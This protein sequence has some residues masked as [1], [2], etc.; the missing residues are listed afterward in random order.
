VVHLRGGTT[1]LALVQ[2]DLLGGSAVVQHLVAR[3][4]AETTDVPLAGLYI[5]ATHTHAGP[6][7][8]LGT[9]FYNKFA[10]N[11]PGFDPAW[12]QFLVQQIADG[13]QQAVDTRRPAR[14]AVGSTEVWGLTRNRS[15]EPH[16]RNPSV[17]DARLEPQR[18]FVSVNPWL[19]LL[20]V[21]AEASDGGFEPLAASVIFSVHGTGISMKSKEYNADVWAYLCDELSRRIESGT[22]TRAVVGAMEGTHADVAPAI[23]PATA[24]HLE[25]SRIGRGIGA[26]AAALHERLEAELSEQVT[27]GCGT[28]EIDLDVSTEVDGIRLPRRPAVGAALVAGAHENLTPVIH[29]VP[30]FTPGTP[31]RR[32]HPD[33]GGK[34]VL[35]GRLGQPLVLRLKMMPSV[36]P[37]QVLRIGDTAIVGLPFE[38]TVDTGRRIESAVGAAVEGNGIDRVVVSSVANEYTGYVTTPEEYARQHYEG[39]HTL[40][41]PRT[42]PFLTA[43]AARLARAVAHDGFVSEPVPHRHFDLKVRRFLAAPGGP[44]VERRSVGRAVFEDPTPATDGAWEVRWFDVS[45]GDLDWHN[46]FARIE[47]SDGGGP[48]E[49]ATDGLRPVDD[50]GCDLQ[51]SHLGSGEEGHRYGVRWWNP[52]F[53]A[54]RRHRLVLASNGPQPEWASEPFD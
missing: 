13:V 3:A 47:R 51:V 45:P 11:K 4:V 22:G 2:C 26:H 52:S 12:T 32:Q 7:Q 17:T 20:R 24:G 39:G 48:W 53:R 29:R 14:L 6:G 10:S 40:F 28:R 18:K 38:L 25:A 27:L 54:G 46:P 16:T 1:S 19:H 5:G 21:D 36:L 35:G 15:L 30:P 33:Q 41:G 42:Q 50:Q 37:L 49:P 43:H 31:K 44:P 9:D 23:R 34:W 8:F